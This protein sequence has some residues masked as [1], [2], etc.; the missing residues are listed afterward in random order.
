MEDIYNLEIP[1]ADDCILWLWTTHK[2]LRDAFDILKKWGF[3]Y[4]ATLV[5]NKDKMGIG[6]KLR[7][8][9]EFCLLG[10]KGKPLWDATDIRDIITEKRREHS[11]KPEKF[12]NMID[13]KFVGKKLDYFSREVREGWQGYGT[14]E[15]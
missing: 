11:R 7:M 8:Q 13:D 3:D 4:K 10:I 15:F 14:K 1:A 5:W 2:Y 6:R 12:Y 9:C